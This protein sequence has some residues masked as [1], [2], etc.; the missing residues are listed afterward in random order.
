MGR[1]YIAQVADTALST[2]LT[3]S[4]HRHGA[5]L[6]SLFREAAT[7]LSPVTMSWGYRP[8]LVLTHESPQGDKEP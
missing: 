4:K 5:K 1:R 7:F 6:L 3:Q 8:I 2:S